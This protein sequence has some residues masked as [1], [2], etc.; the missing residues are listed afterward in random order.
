M[1]LIDLKTLNAI[2]EAKENL[3]NNIKIKKENAGK[4]TEYC[5]KHGYTK[6]TCRC[7]Y[8]GLNDEDPKIRK[9]ANFAYNFGWK[10]KGKTCGCV[11]RLRNKK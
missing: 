10:S 3:K 11:E 9:E 2:E 6:V 8:K 5:K 4:F 7:I 1:M